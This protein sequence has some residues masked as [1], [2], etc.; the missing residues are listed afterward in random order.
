MSSATNGFSSSNRLHI[1]SEHKSRSIPAST[2]LLGEALYQLRLDGSLYCQSEL[3][4]PWGIQMPEFEGNMMFHIVTHGE[5]LLKVEGAAEV[6]L[7]AG[8]FVLL[9]H[10][11][12]HCILSPDASEVVPL[13]DI[14]VEQ[15]NERYEI[16]KHGEG[17]AL[18]RLTCGVVSFNHVI[19]ARLLSQLPSIIHLEEMS[20]AQNVWLQSTLSFIA[21]EAEQAKVGGETIMSHLAD[22]LVIQA[23]RHWIIGSKEAEQGWLGALRDPKIGKALKA[24]HRSPAEPWSVESLASEAGMSRS[25]FSAR[26]TQ[27]VG[28]SVKQYLTEWRMNIAKSKL[29]NT[30]IT[31]GEL[32]ESLGYQSEA[33][34]SRAY[35]RIMGVSPIR[36][37]H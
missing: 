22:I 14:E 33:A 24:V 8:S 34:F 36:H 25:G 37:N 7:K 12:G 5:C 18:T 4:A 27:V 29:K 31:L 2:D 30:A 19:G 17:G 10:G 21:A 26:F 9:P 16:M 32:S 3:T 1:K 35:K 11:K 23:I 15:L 6:L 13:F 20:L 28:V